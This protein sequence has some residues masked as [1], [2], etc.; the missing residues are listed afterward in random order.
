MAELTVQQVSGRGLKIEFDTPTATTGD[1]FDN[2]PNGV[3]ALLV[4]NG[5]ASP[6]TVTVVSEAVDGSGL[7]DDMVVTVAAGETAAIGRIPRS[8]FGAST[9]IICAPVT[10]IGIA[11]LKL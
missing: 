1:T 3:Y 7:D 2:N 9:T 8:R 6:T 10:S 5:S 4:K 11:V